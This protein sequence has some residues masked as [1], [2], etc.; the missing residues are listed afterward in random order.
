MYKVV[1]TFEFLGDAGWSVAWSVFAYF[2]NDFG[3]FLF[4]RFLFKAYAWIL[5][6]DF[7]NTF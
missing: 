7:Y 2:Y 1:G 6:A 4:F 5:I 3:L